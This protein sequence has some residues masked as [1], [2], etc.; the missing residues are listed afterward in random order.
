MKSELKS[1]IPEADKLIE[2]FEN[3]VI[4]FVELTSRLWN[5]GYHAGMED[6]IKMIKNS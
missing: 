5:Y 3:G 2:D 4:N 1:G 6:S